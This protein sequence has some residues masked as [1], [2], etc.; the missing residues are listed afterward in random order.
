MQNIGVEYTLKATN[1]RILFVSQI[2]NFYSYT[3]NMFS[4]FTALK[5]INTLILLI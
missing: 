5:I 3:T 1:C 2:N 4:T